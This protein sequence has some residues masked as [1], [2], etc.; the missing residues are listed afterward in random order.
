MLR[1]VALAFPFN[2]LLKYESLSGWLRVMVAEDTVKL[3]NFFGKLSAADGFWIKT[4]VIEINVIPACTGWRS[5]AAF[6]AL[7]LAVPNVSWEKRVKALVA[8]PVIYF[9]NLGRLAS[10][11]FAAEIGKTKLIHDFLW[12]E[13]LVFLVLFLWVIWWRSAERE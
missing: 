13:G 6:L 1:F 8:V 3:L 12:R 7:V 4:A 11:V 5:V 2:L 9:V 10:L